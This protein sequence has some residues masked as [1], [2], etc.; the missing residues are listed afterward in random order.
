MPAMI[1]VS[2]ISDSTPTESRSNWVNS[3]KRPGSGLV[4]AP[5][6]RHLVAAERPRQL[7]VLGDHAGER[8]GEVEAQAERLVLRVADA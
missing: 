2:A 5:H 8:H 1:S 3:R 7:G 6:R 4:G